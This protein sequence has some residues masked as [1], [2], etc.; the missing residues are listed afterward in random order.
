LAAVRESRKWHT[1]YEWLVLM[2]GSALGY[3]G[4]EPVAAVVITAALLMFPTAQRDIAG[5]TA[6]VALALVT[7][8]AVLFGT[9]A[10]FM[11][12]GIAWLLSV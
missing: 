5:P 9:A 10:Y 3:R 1:M 12:K 8:N 6:K 4:V 11:G 2:L 7:A